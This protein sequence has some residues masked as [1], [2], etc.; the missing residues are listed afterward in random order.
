MNTI[1]MSKRILL[2][3]GLI[4][5]LSNNINAQ[6]LKEKAE[7][8]D[9][10]AQYQYAQK[11]SDRMFPSKE[12]LSEAVQWLTKSALQGYAPAQCSLGYCY[13]AGKG[14]KKDYLT[15]FNWYQKSA[16]QGNMTAQFNMGVCYA[17][18]YGVAE[19]K[20]TAFNWYK[21]SADQGYVNAEVALAKCYYY[22][23]GTTTNN[24]IAFQWFTKAAE[25]KNAEA[26][27]FLGEC[28]ANGFGI[29]QNLQTAI[30]WYNKAA[31]DDDEKAEFALAQLYLTGRGVEKDTTLATDLLLHSAAGGFCSPSHMF[32][33]HEGYDRAL[34]KLKELTNHETS[35]SHHYFL[36][37]LGCYYHS[38]DDYVNAEKYYKMAI[39]ENSLLGV[40]ELGL[41][42]YYIWVN[43]PR[44]GELEYSTSLASS[45]DKRL[46]DFMD[47]E[48]WRHS[49]NK[50]V[51]DYLK[52]K[53]WS[54]KDNAIYWM[55][56][57]INYGEGD[58]SY[59][60]DGFTIYDHI[61]F[62]LNDSLSGYTN[63][64][65]ALDISF[66][67]LADTTDTRCEGALSTISI[68]GKT[69]VTQKEVDMLLRLR[70]FYAKFENLETYKKKFVLQIVNSGLGYCYYKGIG[71][72][73]NYKKAFSFLL[74]GAELGDSDAMGLLAAC[75]RYGRGTQKNS[76]KDREWTAKA[77]QNRNERARKL[78]ELRGN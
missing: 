51:I 31:D 19:S 13:W 75:Y 7:S 15:A 23:N 10:V 34:R 27:F 29:T 39:G 16:E 44:E 37:M 18:G 42:Y 57:A 60:A 5:L 17:N 48:G 25:K 73:R 21:K 50:P 28:Y 3:V 41:M 45:E 26:M 52:E 67:C 30:E 40:I 65:K 69:K 58:F 55:E 9:K 56:K 63:R 68:Y 6:S 1:K 77:V 14:V 78:A 54:D 70:D 32:N 49:D 22:G 33:A 46:G 72:E 66:M 76:S 8:G 71:V 61:L 12:D 24:T 62:L 4:A 38:V 2:A 64:S 74:E 47:L 20:Y 11:F 53:K 59:G 43:Q 36:A 35:P